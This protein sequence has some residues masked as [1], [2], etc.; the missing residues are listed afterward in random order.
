MYRFLFLFL[1]TAALIS[2]TASF[3]S[4]E[5][6]K[7]TGDKPAPPADKAKKSRAGKTTPPG[8]VSATPPAASID[9]EKIPADWRDLKPTRNGTP[10]YI[11]A[12]KWHNPVLYHD[13]YVYARGWVVHVLN[14]VGKDGDAC[15][16]IMLDEPYLGL[17]NE[18]NSPGEIHVEIIHQDKTNSYTGGFRESIYKSLGI[19]TTPGLKG[20][21]QTE[22]RDRLF[23]EFTKKIDG[24]YVEVMGVWVVDTGHN[25]KSGNHWREIHPCVRLR[26]IDPPA[27]V[28][29]PSRNRKAPVENDADEDDDDD[30]EKEK[31]TTEPASPR[32]PN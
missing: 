1:A 19:T 3:S 7:K 12:P 5:P 28:K 9:R 13:G 29:P 26:V 8:S 30:E 14:N 21:E 16:N 11:P 17:R 20:K 31:K 27:G 15:F 23:K 6:D 24:K 10:P 32:K 4:E 2:G 18:F 22:E 25:V